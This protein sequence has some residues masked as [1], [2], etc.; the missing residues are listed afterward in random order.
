[1]TPR[2]FPL[3]VATALS[4]VGC[5]SETGAPAG[6]EPTDDRTPAQT[7]RPAGEGSTAPAPTNATQDPAKLGAPYPVVLLHG[8]AGFG[9]LE[10]GPASVT[11]FNGIVEDLT[12]SGESVYATIA[13]PYETSEVRAAAIAQQIDQILARTGK[14]KV[15]IVGHSQGGL[16]ARV[17]A[18]PNG[19]GY[20]DRIASVTTV[21]TP[22]RGSKVAD[23][24][25]GLIKV[26]PADVVDEVTGGLLQLLEK[27]AYELQTDPNLRAQVTLLSETYMRDVF[28]PKYVDDSRV[29]YRSYAGRTNLRTGLLACDGSTYPNDPTE[30]DVA[31]LPLGTLAAFLEDGQLKVNDGLVT[32]ESAKWGKFEQC[33]AAD[34]LKEV[35]QL[36]TLASSF[37]HI[38]LF[39]NI[40]SRIRAA[41]F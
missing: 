27:S 38:A 20:G 10:V 5:G 36:G 31:Q 28:N 7:S 9:K 1:M 15:N 6:G 21:A 40:V 25:L 41:G 8:M 30:L 26:L 4:M 3:L 37:D 23:A 29:L 39:R 19:L 18:S 2:I 12:K 17:L 11:Y 13:P 14:A 24:A 33:V 32:V 22:H 16:D 35:G 34:H